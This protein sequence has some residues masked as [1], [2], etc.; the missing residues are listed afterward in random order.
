MMFLLR[1][2]HTCLYAAFAHL[3]FSQIFLSRF[4]SLPLVR[5]PVAC[6]AAVHAG[7]GQ[8]QSGRVA[9]AT[10]TIRRAPFD[11]CLREPT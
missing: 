4:A 11:S 6:W 10:G 2:P 8:H 7:T 1:R 5:Y 9:G 3:L